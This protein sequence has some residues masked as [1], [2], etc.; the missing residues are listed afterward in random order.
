M[1]FQRHLM[2]YGIVTIAALAPAPPEIRAVE[3]ARVPPGGLWVLAVPRNGGDAATVSLLGETH[4]MFPREGRWLAPL[5]IYA[6]TK[7]GHYTAIVREGDRIVDRVPY[8][9]VPK[10]FPTQ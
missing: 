4:P 2:I 3:A 7:P 8:V 1:S 6:R 9:I 5:A 10:T